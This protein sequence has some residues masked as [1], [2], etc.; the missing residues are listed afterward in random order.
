M[1]LAYKEDDYKKFQDEPVELQLYTHF[2]ELTFDNVN[3]CYPRNVTL[4]NNAVQRF[5]EFAVM[6]HNPGEYQTEIISM[7][8]DTVDFNRFSSPHTDKVRPLC[9]I[10]RSDQKQK[11]QRGTF[12]RIYSFLMLLKPV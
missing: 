5:A 7:Q 4:A 6:N 12:F 1:A 3:S 8:F 9:F 10:L 2:L 11:V